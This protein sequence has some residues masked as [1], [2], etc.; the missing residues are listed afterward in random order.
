MQEDRDTPTSSAAPFLPQAVNVDDTTISHSLL[1]SLSSSPA[2]VH[3]SPPHQLL[4]LTQSQ[5]S[6][7]QNYLHQ[8]KF[9]LENGSIRLE[10]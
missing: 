4:S 6:H 3:S 1:T 7:L 8:D 10:A 5:P 2:L 9:Y